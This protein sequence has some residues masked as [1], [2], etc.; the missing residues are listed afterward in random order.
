[1]SALGAIL[2]ESIAHDGPMALD[3][4]M[5]VALGH[6]RHGYYMTR[7]PFG[8]AGDFITAPEI[9]QMFGEL[10][11]LWAAETWRLLGAPERVHLVELGPGR[12]TLMRDA[13]R[14]A[15]VSNEFCAALD[16][17]LVETSPVLTQ[18][19]KDCLAQAAVSVTWHTSIDSVPD[20]PAI[21]IANEFFDALPVRHYVKTSDGW[22]QRLVGLDA[23]GALAFGLASD[24]ETLIKAEAPDGSVLELSPVSQLLM[25]QIATRI[26]KGQSA[27]LVIDYGH[28]ETGFGETLQA[29]K[30]HQRVNPLDEPGE[31][32]L[33][34]HV[35]F[36]ALARAASSAGAQVL[37]PVTQGE[38]LLRLGI[39]QR[40]EALKRKATEEQARDVDLAL[41]RLVT[42]R[43]GQ[44]P[45]MGRLFKALAVTPPGAPILPGFLREGGQP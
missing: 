8:A 33:T 7:D 25:T 13:L 16:V 44:A 10:I 38:F 40:A 34:A 29:L 19:Q 3:T 43:V 42:E 30:K 17:H 36:A 22:R 4:F 11:G 9:S 5:A 41:A 20:G 35:D 23:Q 26:A 24:T 28:V 21:F 27:A 1:M 15:R 2:R 45:G 18:A 32:D 39:A 31:A 37:G 12:G 14:A 6:S